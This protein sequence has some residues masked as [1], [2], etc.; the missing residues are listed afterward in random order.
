MDLKVYYEKIREHEA[1]LSG[2]YQVVVSVATADGGKAGVRSEVPN[3]IAA[4][5][6]LDGIARLANAKEAEHFRALQVEAKRV[7]DELAAA[8]K[9]QISVVSR[10]E[11]DRM[12]A[13]MRSRE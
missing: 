5:M 13:A 2:D 4:R 7:A 8:S 9:M 10:D 3:R 1:K 11:L 6:V 12:R